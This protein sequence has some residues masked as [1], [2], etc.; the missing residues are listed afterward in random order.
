MTPASHVR[1]T[2]MPNELRPRFS[3]G[4]IAKAAGVSRAAVYDLEKKAIRK[5]RRAIEQEAKIAGVTVREW[6]FGD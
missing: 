3:Q 2:S 6:L 5:L 4:D 1:T